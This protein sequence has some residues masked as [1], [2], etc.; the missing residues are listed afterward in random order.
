MA[1]LHSSTTLTETLSGYC[2][3]FL[4]VMLVLSCCESFVTEN[5]RMVIQVRTND[6]S[7]RPCDEIYV[8]REGE[9]LHTIS[10][11]CGD[12]YIVEENPHI[13]DPD[14]V[15]PGLVIKITPFTNR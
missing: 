6:M 4:A 11:K 5:E 14:D 7:Y 1:R 8:V 2:S 10:E 13:H 9:T 3:L 12:P 15:F